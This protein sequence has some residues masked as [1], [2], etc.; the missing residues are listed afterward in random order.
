MLNVRIS[1]MLTFPNIDPVAIDFGVWRLPVI[2]AIHPQVHWYGVMYLI[3]FI[4]CYWLVRYR[5]GVM[6]KTPVRPEQVGDLLFYVALGVVLGGRVGYILFYSFSAFLQNPLVLFRV[7]EGGMSF[8]GGL[9]GV[10]LA[11]WWYGR[12]IGV[13]FWQMTDLIAPSIP[14]GLL[15]GRIGNFINAE[16]WGRIT[17]LPWGMVFPNGGALPRHPSMVYE[18]ILEGVILFVILWL[19]SAKPRPRMAVSAV[20]ALGYGVFRFCVE[21]VREPDE[22]IGFIAFDWLTMGMLLSL[23]MIMVGLVLFFLVYR[24]ARLS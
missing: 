16:L 6:P 1:A 2:G 17:D 14:F 24:R 5:T 21:F 15:C 3:A 23:P 12:K 20:F 19:Y 7:W 10:L 4:G 9:L 18:A 13:T 11:V 8:H 22:H